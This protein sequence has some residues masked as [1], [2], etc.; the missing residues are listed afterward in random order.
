M[1]MKCT[2][3]GSMLYRSTRRLRA[4]QVMT[5]TRA[6]ASP[7]LSVIGVPMR[8]PG[9]DGVKRRCDGNR[10]LAAEIEDGETVVRAEDAVFVLDPEQVEVLTPVFEW[11][12]P[13]EDGHFCLGN[14]LGNEAARYVPLGDKADHTV[15]SCTAPDVH[16]VDQRFGKRRNPATGWGVSAH[17]KNAGTR[18]GFLHSKLLV[19]L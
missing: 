18:R 7:R 4:C 3:L 8:R 14:N 6:A 15:R 11:V 9:E 17:K 10:G 2:F 12:C 19:L 16:R 1:G 13:V 5:T